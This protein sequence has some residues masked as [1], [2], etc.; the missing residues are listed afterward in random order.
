M[1]GLLWIYLYAILRLLNKPFGDAQCIT[2]VRSFLGQ[3]EIKYQKLLLARGQGRTNFY[4]PGK[5]N[6]IPSRQ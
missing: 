3:K 4:M 5:A 1:I 2:K 6:G